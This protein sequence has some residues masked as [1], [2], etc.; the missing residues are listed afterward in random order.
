MT[1]RYVQLPNGSYLQWPEGVSAATFKAKATKLM[2]P[3]LPVSTRK[4]ADLSLPTAQPPKPFLG[5]LLDYIGKGME[6]TA[7]TPSSVMSGA[8]NY[9]KEGQQQGGILGAVKMAE[10][11]ILA[12]GDALTG[13]L[14]SVL[15]VSTPG[16]LYR[17]SKKEDPAKIAADASTFLGGYALGGPKETA[18]G[19]EFSVGD[20]AK[21][22]TDAVNPP[23]KEMASFQRSIGQHLDKIVTFAKANGIDIGSVDGLAKAMKGSGDW[24]RSHYY[25]EILGP[26]KDRPVSIAGTIPGYGGE[27]AS[28]STATLGQLD[29]RLSQINAELN[30]RYSKGGMAG[31]AAVK[32]ATELNA[33]SA[34]I[35][36]QL[37]DGVGKATGLTPEQVAQTRGSFGA[38]ESL[39][40]K[41]ANAAAK[42]R[43]ATNK[44]ARA[45]IT[46]NPFGDSGKQFI[47]DK[48]VNAVRGDVVGKGIKTALGKV[49]VK[50]YELPAAK[51][52]S[53]TARVRTPLRGESGIKTNVETSGPAE[54]AAVSEKLDAR[55]TLNEVTRKKAELDRANAGTAKAIKSSRHPFWRDTRGSFEKGDR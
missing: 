17:M 24:I 34:G 52:A 29:A 40:E 12:E 32:S 45:P 4:A 31:Q 28:P 55:R 10:S 15:G 54:R 14:K 36:K 18:A 49:K 33:E 7:R 26:V 39:A 21:Q 44:S 3:S 38:L 23:P 8:R 41:T 22:I 9:Y 35:R 1:D 20:A 53:V 25:N 47:A 37:Y 43:Y 11:P 42:E 6:S 30:P 27:T 50:P 51:P 16:I 13:M 46:V 2:G 5:R 19:E 48:A